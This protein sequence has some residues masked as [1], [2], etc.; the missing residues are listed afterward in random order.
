L[1][2]ELPFGSITACVRTVQQFRSQPRLLHQFQPSTV[3]AQI[4]RHLVQYT[5][6]MTHRPL[7]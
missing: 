5:P 3:H 7:L 1:P 6:N 2:E 4:H